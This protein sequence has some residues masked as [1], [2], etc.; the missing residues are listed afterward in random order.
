MKRADS[1]GR[2][3][4]RLVKGKRGR[5]P[6]DD[7]DESRL[8]VQQRAMRRAWRARWGCDAAAMARELA[9]PELP[10]SPRA[11]ASWITDAP[12]RRTPAHKY[13]VRLAQV[14]GTTPEALFR[15]PGIWIG[16]HYYGPEHPLYKRLFAAAAAV[17]PTVEEE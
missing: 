5:P 6:R 3:G 10:V 2:W 15:E 14:L 8:T 1:E 17:D 4:D 12:S 11:V 9:T 13:I 16:T 7:V